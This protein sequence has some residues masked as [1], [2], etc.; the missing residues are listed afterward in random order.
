MLK[1]STQQGNL[2]R[3]RFLQARELIVK[4]L[5]TAMY[6][7]YWARKSTRGRDQYNH[8]ISLYTGDDSD[9][10]GG[11]KKRW[12]NNNKSLKNNPRKTRQ[13][14]GCRRVGHIKRDCKSICQKISGIN[15]GNRS[16]LECP[17][18]KKKGH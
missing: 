15:T 7:Y 14:Y 11:T 12:S 5:R 8:E 18:C 13:C 4:E 17:F 9:G 1:P 3:Q 10:S 16:T 2:P 6:E